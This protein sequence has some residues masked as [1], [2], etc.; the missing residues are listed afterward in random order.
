MAGFFENLKKNFENKVGMTTDELINSP[1]RQKEISARSGGNIKFDNTNPQE[2]YANRLSP[3]YATA[4]N[5]IIK[6]YQDEFKVTPRATIG[7][8]WDKIS[9]D[10]TEGLAFS[11]SDK[12]GQYEV[13]VKGLDA[14]YER[15]ARGIA[16]DSEKAGWSVKGSGGNLDNVPT[17][18][19]GHVLTF[20]LFPDNKDTEK[21]Y[22]DSLKDLGVSNDKAAAEAVSKISNYAKEGGI[23]ETI[24][25]ALTDYYY[26]RDKSAPLS[27]AIVRR[28]KS[29]GSTYGLRQSGGVDTNR[30]ADNF[31]K[32]LRRYNVIQ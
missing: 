10:N 14:P 21:L 24:A 31:F 2:N 32:N 16:S 17:H 23:H 20:Q 26:N 11:N 22:K 27:Q 18:E 8:D 5:N 30:S 12:T 6:F 19:L 25:E 15:R 4:L 13:Q 29:S 1:R 7:S 28:L 9:N 3:N